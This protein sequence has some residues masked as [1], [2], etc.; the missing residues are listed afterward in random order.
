MKIAVVGC[1][2]V[3]GT[4]ADFLEEH[5]AKDGVEVIRCDPAKYP[6]GPSSDM[7]RELTGAIFCINAPTSLDDEVDIHPLRNAVNGVMNNNPNVEIM[8]KSTIPMFTKLTQGPADPESWKEEII[9]NPE[10]LRESTAKEDFANQKHFIIGVAKHLITNDLPAKDNPHAKFW[11][12]ILHQ[13]CPT[14]NLFTLIVKLL[15]WSSIHIM[16]GWLQK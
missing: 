15:Q 4:V 12:N 13:V 9:F 2:F 7:L 11:T 3:G 6:D 16:L 10:F 8:V 1:G 5:T 14:L